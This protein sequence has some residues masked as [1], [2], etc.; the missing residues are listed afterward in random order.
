M[1][2]VPTRRLTLA[3]FLALGLVWPAGGARGEDVEWRPD[4]GSA[5]REASEKDRP[6]L[7]DIGS[8]DCLWC[9]RLD[10]VTFRDASVARLLNSHFVPVRLDADKESSL[11]EKLRVQALPTVL[12]AGPDGRVLDVIE[13]FKDAA[14]LKERLER[15][16]ARNA[17]PEARDA[18]RARQAREALARARE[19]FRAGQY[20][21]C[22]ARCDVVATTYA[23]LPEAADALALAGEIRKNP[24]WLRQ[25][26]DNL[27]D[28]LATTYLALAD[29]WLMKGQPHQAALCLE[30]VL[31]VLPGTRHA[32]AAQAR[33]ARIQGVPPTQPVEYKK[34]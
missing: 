21:A 17:P 8:A 34:D 28:Q 27:G 22:L 15:V 26:C 19:E 9:K 31:Q 5:R 24:E 6:L 32:D 10:A 12:L 33:L 16:A 7:L 3:A 20:A 1:T 11:V 13:G 25:A 2:M 14:A 18:A 4:Y 30:R 23:G 29:A